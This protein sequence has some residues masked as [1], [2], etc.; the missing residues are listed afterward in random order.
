MAEE[1]VV[2]LAFFLMTLAMFFAVLKYPKQALTKFR[3]KNRNRTTVQS[4]HHLAQA[5]NLLERTRSIHRKAQSLAHAKNALAEAEKVVSLSPRDPAAHIIKAL[6]LDLMDRQTSALRSLDLALSPPCAK[7]LSR[8]ERGDALVKRAEL[9]LA[10]NRKRRVDSA[11]DDLIEAVRLCDG[12]AGSRALCLL[13]QCYEWKGLMESTR[14]NCEKALSMEPGS[15]VARQG[16]G[17]SGS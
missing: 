13:G 12:D 17:R 3:T 16:L 1:L 6:A 2:Q 8:G 11:V 15:F 14:E 9:K 10:M 5:S 7:S 4:S